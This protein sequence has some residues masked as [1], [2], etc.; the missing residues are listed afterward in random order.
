MRKIFG[1]ENILQSSLRFTVQS[2]K[3]VAHDGPGS[4]SVS[5]ALSDCGTSDSQNPPLETVKSEL[6]ESLLHQGLH[7]GLE[8]GIDG[9]ETF[10]ERFAPL[11]GGREN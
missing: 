4:E 10:F 7:G 5:S 6:L 3:E 1:R 8:L 2:D 11:L 9:I